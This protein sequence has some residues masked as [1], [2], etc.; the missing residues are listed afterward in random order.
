MK[1]YFCLLIQVPEEESQKRIAVVGHYEKRVLALFVALW[2]SQFGKKHRMRK[3][4][5]KLLYPLYNQG[6]PGEIMVAAVN[7]DADAVMFK[8][9]GH[10]PFDRDLIP[11]R[12]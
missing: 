12:T 9:V 11:V 10:D 5:R 2:K 4:G 3:P 7:L 6:L 8:Q 1:G